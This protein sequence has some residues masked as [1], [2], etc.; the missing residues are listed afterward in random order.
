VRDRH[1]INTANGVGRRINQSVLYLQNGIWFHGTRVSNF[2][3]L[4][5][6]SR[7]FPAPIFTKTS[8]SVYEYVQIFCT[9]FHRT[10]A[11]NVESTK[12]KVRYVVKCGVH[13]DDFHETRNHSVY[14]CEHRLH[15]ISSASYETIENM[16]N[17][18]YALK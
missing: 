13:R 4:H 5:N 15:S 12:I 9:D 17:L 2:I 3:Y 16:V 10:R 1:F 11:M 7:N 14:F 18:I 8:P 6:T